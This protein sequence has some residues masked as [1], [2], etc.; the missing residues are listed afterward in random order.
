[1]FR[2]RGQGFQIVE[3]LKWLAG[4]GIFQSQLVL[5]GAIE[6]F[7]HRCHFFPGHSGGGMCDFA[8]QPGHQGTDI[9]EA[10][11][12]RRTGAGNITTAGHDGQRQG[13]ELP[14]ILGGTRPT[15]GGMAGGNNDITVPG[16][17]LISQS[18]Q[19]ERMLIGLL[20]IPDMLGT[21]VNDLAPPE[22]SRR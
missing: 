17:R 18:P 4:R 3:F 20:F 6:F 19:E 2:G 16:Y 15:G 22:Q 14:G 8:Q 13:R 9:I 7:H 11:R 1:M 5:V 10:Q 21:N 12:L